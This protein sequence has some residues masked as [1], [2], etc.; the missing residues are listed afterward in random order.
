[1]RPAGVAGTTFGFYEDIGGHAR[2]LDMRLVPRAGRLWGL[3]GSTPRAKGA[4]RRPDTAPRPRRRAHLRR[5]AGVEEAPA[6][7]VGHPGPAVPRDRG[8]E[9]LLKRR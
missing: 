2:R 7:S 6:G 1:M 3:I 5:E 4:G 9:R 8:R